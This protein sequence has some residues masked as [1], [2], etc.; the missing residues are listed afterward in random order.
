MNKLVTMKKSLLIGIVLLVLAGG[1]G[2]AAYKH[3]Y[4]AK[5]AVIKK[6]NLI[7][8]GPPTQ[9]DKSDTQAHKEALANQYQQQNNS[10]PS[11]SKQIV[12]PVI[13]NA[14]E[15][16]QQVTVNS[17]IDGI[18]ENGGTCTATFTQGAIQIVRS[19][20]AFANATTT[21][22]PPF[23]LKSSEFSPTGRWQV[24]VTYNSDKASGTSQPLMFTVK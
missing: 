24:I 4:P 12:T 23:S 9:Q 8:Y 17:Y 22:C 1:C 21:N 18:F 11:N 19:D 13:T 6:N 3:Y 20:T 16:G 14:S 15:I 10:P 5:A 7:N 2:A